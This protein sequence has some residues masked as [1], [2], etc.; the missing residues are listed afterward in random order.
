MYSAI[1]S[2]CGLFRYEL[3]FVIGDTGPVASVLMVN[4]S[5]ADGVIKDATVRKLDGFGARLGWSRYIVA[6][7]HAFRATDVNELKTAVDPV[8][9]L[10]HGHL[11]SV[12][13][14]SD[15]TV[16]AWGSLAKLP[17]HLRNNWRAVVDMA[18]S[19]NRPLYCWGVC[20]DGHPK[21][22]VMIGYDNQLVEWNP[23]A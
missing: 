9:P 19:L 15:I 7:K 12:M 4:P 20:A 18:R 5:K 8:G 16:V 13:M 23:P 1:I 21:H 2:D 17:P 6:N 22:P 11:L 14:R 3:E 10:N